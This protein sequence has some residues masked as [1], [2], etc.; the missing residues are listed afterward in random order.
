[1]PRVFMAMRCEDD[2]PHYFWQRQDAIEYIMERYE[3]LHI[4]DLRA[5]DYVATLHYLT[6]NYELPGIGYWKEIT[7]E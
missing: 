2:K 6:V 7:I 3:E 4:A 1:M 5:T